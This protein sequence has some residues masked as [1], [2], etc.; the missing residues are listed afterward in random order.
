MTRAKWG[1]AW[2][3][4]CAR[5]EVA[6]ERLSLLLALSMVALS[7]SLSAFAVIG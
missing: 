1:V 3:M 4:Q 5:L 6:M 7:L 2:S